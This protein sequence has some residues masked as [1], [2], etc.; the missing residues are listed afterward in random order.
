MSRLKIGLLLSEVPSKEMLKKIRFAHD[1]GH[2]LFLFCLDEGVTA[3]HEP[4]LQKL[5]TQGHSLFACA[6]GAQ[7][8]D[9]PLDDRATFAGLS[10][11]SDI[12]TSTDEFW[13]VSS[14]APFRPQICDEVP[15]TLVIHAT[16]DPTTQRR[17]AEAVRVA[18]GLQQWG[19]LTLTLSLHGP[20]KRALEH[21]AAHWPDGENFVRYL[22]LLISAGGTIAQD[23]TP[24]ADLVIAI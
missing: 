15:S 21:E 12:L 17:T 23:M 24:A 22:P 20:A 8:R 18:A 2:R 7:R 5:R 10:M 16:A 19:R 9:I 6:Y 14:A 3:L 4:V 13:D 1:A 11:L